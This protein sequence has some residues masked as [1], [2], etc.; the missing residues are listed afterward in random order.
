M[1]HNPLDLP[2]QILSLPDR[3]RPCNPLQGLQCREIFL[4]A[5]VIR[6]F[7]IQNQTK[8]ISNTSEKAMSFQQKMT[9]RL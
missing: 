8:P 1:G 2:W 6:A 9:I 5:G 7:M 4:S 3:C